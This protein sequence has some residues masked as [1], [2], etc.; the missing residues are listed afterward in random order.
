MF[1]LQGLLARLIDVTLIVAGAAVA[2]EVRLDEIAAQQSFDAAFVVFA[3]AFALALFPVFGVYQSW[4]GRSILRLVG[5]VSVAWIFVQGCSLVLAFALHRTDF[6]SRLWFAY[7]TAIAGGCLVMMR[8]SVHTV[9]GRMRHAGLNL[10]KVAI[11]GCDAHCDAVV[12]K[13]EALPA[14]GFRPAAIFSVRPL[15][16]VS[17]SKIPVFDELAAFAEHIRS[18]GVQELWLTLPLSEERT[19]LL[20]VNEFRNELVNVRFIPDVRSLA[21]FDG[22]MIDLIGSPAINLL[23]SPLSPRALVQKEIFDR[24]FAAAVLLSCA[25]VLIGISIA[26]KLSSPG[27]V[28]FKQRRKGADGR[29]FTIYKF[30]SMRMHIEQAGVVKQATRDDPRITRVGA[31]LR[32]SSLDE[33]P[34]FINVLHGEMSV[35]GPRPHAIEHDELYH[36]IVEG[37]I[38]RYRIKPGITGWAQ[39]NGFRGETDHVEKMQLRVEHDLYYLRNWSFA[40]DMRIV[41]ATITNGLTH[42]NAY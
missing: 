5:Q 36:K 42:S 1:G 7:W 30:R 23:A 11:V 39:V 40:L 26:V 32:R 33:L 22:P 28:L 17:N 13:I 34:Q 27:P 2:A 15:A 29:V 9:L 14:S 38:H 12:R 6:I 41:A 24:A 10:R 16:G 3:S 4:R 19:I 20:M 31:F 25:P 8:V 21:L 37:Y 18:E 35:V